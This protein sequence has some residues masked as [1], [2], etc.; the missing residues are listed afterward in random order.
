MRIKRIDYW[1]VAALI[2]PLLICPWLPS[3]DQA[4]LKDGGIST[5]LLFGLMPV[6]E[7]IVFRGWLQGGLLKLERFRSMSA[8]LSRA[9][10]LTSLLF[11]LAHLWQHPLML[12][13]GYLVVSLLLGYFRDRYQ[14]LGVPV[15]LHSYF[16][17]C[18]Y[19]LAS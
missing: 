3:W 12:L 18:L 9:N 16:N 5:V 11:A 4:Y 13:P 6:V 17:L 7:E 10:W 15:L 2:A 8:G 14:G 19:L 1:L